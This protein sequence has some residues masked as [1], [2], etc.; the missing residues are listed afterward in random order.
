MGL[1]QVT[2]PTLLPFTLNEVKD[3]L[4]VYGTDD[5][6]YLNSIIPAASSVAGVIT[7]RSIAYS[8]WKLHLDFFPSCGEIVIPNPPLKSVTS[9]KYYDTSNVLQTLAADQYDVDLISEP[10]RICQ[11]FNVSWP[12]TYRRPN[13]VEVRYFSGYQTREAIP[14]GLKQ[15]MLYHIG[16]MFEQRTPVMEGRS[17][18]EVP[19]TMEYLYWPYRVMRFF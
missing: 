12:D 11:A 5:D 2:A 17:V 6:A 8:E 9:I 14:A 18:Q 19:M 7:R 4:R 3:H 10:G 15:A 1:E 13:A 16:L